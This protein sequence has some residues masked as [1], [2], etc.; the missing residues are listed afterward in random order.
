MLK[1]FSHYNMQKVEI[2]ASARSHFAI[3]AGQHVC[4]AL[5]CI[6]T[7][8]FDQ[9][10]WAKNGLR[11]EK[12]VQCAHT[13]C[14]SGL[15]SLWPAAFRWRTTASSHWGQL[16]FSVWIIVGTRALE[17]CLTDAFGND[18][19]G[20]HGN[21]AHSSR[22]LWLHN[23]GGCQ[24]RQATLDAP[25]ETFWISCEILESRAEGFVEDE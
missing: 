24:V 20:T 11:P 6:I 10:R 8:I 19:L 13:L 16:V 17:D 4:T 22:S 25:D 15:T 18:S 14:G 3:V 1:L 23:G 12:L 9:F 2:A 5:C 21:S 7:Q